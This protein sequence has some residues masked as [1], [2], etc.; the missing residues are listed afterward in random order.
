MGMTVSPKKMLCRSVMSSTLTWL[1]LVVSC[2]QCDG[3]RGVALPAR[4][5]IARRMHLHDRM[6]VLNRDVQALEGDEV[7]GGVDAAFLPGQGDEVVG[8]IEVALN[9]HIHALD[10]TC[11][12]RLVYA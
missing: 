12:L 2:N 6:I 8:N 5:N 9:D 7:Y 11:S 4:W 10:T 3:W 1:L